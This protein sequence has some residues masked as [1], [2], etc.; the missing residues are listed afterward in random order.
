MG[1]VAS[2]I[3]RL[4]HGPVLSTVARSQEI[5]PQWWPQN[6][7]LANDF[8]LNC[9]RQLPLLIRWQ[10]SPLEGLAI[11]AEDPQTTARLE[12]FFAQR[13]QEYLMPATSFLGQLQF[14]VKFGLPLESILCRLKP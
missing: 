12:Q 3:I 11:A 5:Q 14:Q 2:K 7:L 8:S 4:A 6:I 10:G 13:L 9:A 1:S